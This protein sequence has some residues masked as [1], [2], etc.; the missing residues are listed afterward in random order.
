MNYSIEFYATSAIMTVYLDLCKLNRNNKLYQNVLFEKEV[1]KISDINENRH[2]QIKRVELHELFFDLVFVY[3]IQKIAHVIL[4][5]HHGSISG[6]L[7]FKYIM[8]SL[9]VWIIWSHQTFFI[10][11]FGSLAKK[12]IIFIMFNIFVL[13]FLTNSL[14]PSFEKT[15]TPFFFCV[16]ILYLSIGIQYVLHA[17]KNLND[18]DKRTCQSFALVAFIVA[19]LSFLSLILPSSVHYIPA[20]LG[21]L[22]ASTG[23]IPFR[24]YLNQSP[25]NMMHLVERFSLLTIIIFGEVIIGLASIF[26]ITNFSYIYIF[27][28][29]ILVFMFGTYWI[30]TENYINHKRKSIGFRLVYSHLLINIALGTLNAALVFSNNTEINPYFEVNLMHLSVL[31]FF[32][33]VW[34]NAPYFHDKINNLRHIIS[35]LMMLLISYIM[36]CLFIFNQHVMILSLAISLGLI[37]LMY[38]KSQDS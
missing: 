32:V 31:F 15:F 29:L 18:A 9:I 6:E 25:V 36:S 35:A 7:F 3:A 34:L 17:N 21:V 26:S 37:M 10:N 14:Y 23:L 11:R 19:T 20:F 38:Y 2:L 5:I 1:R 4:H 33:G 13:I 30:V 28:F 24:K 8:M 12:D 27:Q 22:I 16:A